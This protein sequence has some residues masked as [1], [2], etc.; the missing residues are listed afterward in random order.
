MK[1]RTLSILLSGILLL[2]CA[3]CY[4]ADMY[5]FANSEIGLIYAVS[6]DAGEK[7]LLVAS[8]D[9]YVQLYDLPIPSAHMVRGIFVGPERVWICTELSTLYF[10]SCRRGSLKSGWVEKQTALTDFKGM[11]TF[12]GKFVFGTK[13][14]TTGINYF[15]ED[16]SVVSVDLSS[17]TPAN[18]TMDV[19]AI[20]SVSDSLE[21]KNTI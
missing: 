16:G 18:L 15:N 20:F 5:E 13:S 8:E 19:G 12:N 10:Y 1:N 4:R 2:I 7:K 17:T 11:T 14:N 6:D 3:G 21:N 9:G